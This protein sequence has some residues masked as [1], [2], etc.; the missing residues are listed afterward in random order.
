MLLRNCCPEV[1]FINTNLP[2]NKIRMIK[3]IVYKKT[4]KWH[5]SDNEWQRMTTS[6]TTSDNES[7]RV[8]TNEKEWKQMTMSDSERQQVVQRM[9]TAQYTS[10]NGWLPSFL[11]QKQIHYFKG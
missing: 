11:W 5:I 8:T 9:K 7:E 4:D 2:E 1:T 10:K 3:S 6:G